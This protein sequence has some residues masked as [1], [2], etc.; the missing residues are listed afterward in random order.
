MWRVNPFWPPESAPSIETE[1]Q[2]QEITPE[3]CMEEY[4]SCENIISQIEDF[5]NNNPDI[6]ISEQEILDQLWE[7]TLK[8][9]MVETLFLSLDLI[10]TY[11]EYKNNIE[12]ISDNKNKLE[13]YRDNIER[14]FLNQGILY[15]CCHDTPETHL[16][17]LTEIFDIIATLPDSEKDNIIRWLQEYRDARRS[18]NRGFNIPLIIREPNVALER[19]KN[20]SW[21][22]WD[23][24]E[25]QL[26]LETSNSWIRS[27]SE[28]SISSI[29]FNTSARDTLNWVRGIPDSNKNSSWGINNISN[30]PQP[31]QQNQNLD[32]LNI[33]K[34]NKD[35]LEWLLDR[36]AYID[37]NWRLRLRNN[38]LLWNN[39]RIEVSENWELIFVSSLWFDFKFDNDLNISADK[40]FDTITKL[41]FFDK[42]W[43]AI[44]WE[45]FKT[46]YESM[47]LT[48][49]FDNLSIN[50]DKWE[51]LNTIQI[52]Q[53]L[54][55]LNKMW[56][57][58]QT[59]YDTLS[60][61][62]KVPENTFINWVLPDV[63]QKAWQKLFNSSWKIVVDRKDVINYVNNAC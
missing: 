62:Q 52:W 14:D 43:L 19:I 59:S 51:F 38:I 29:S 56:L 54:S 42:L 3:S 30:Q 37:E 53:L 32:N 49:K 5:L 40:L 9:S 45:D 24:N 13:F 10:N 63:N 44:L 8:L 25:H 35:R 26:E 20:N 60:S 2:Q 48:W 4:E 11:P 55:G 17:S 47:K 31:E 58:T 16:S 12:E 21:N 7:S 28:T 18:G 34:E 41:E 33:S 23:S 1:V 27:E 15:F 39:W 36:W 61:V 46:I 57:T 22:N 6:D 50:P